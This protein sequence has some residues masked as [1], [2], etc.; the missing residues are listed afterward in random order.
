[1]ANLTKSQLIEQIDSERRENNAKFISPVQTLALLNRSLN[2]VFIEPGIKTVPEVQTLTASASVTRYA[3]EDDFK[4]L[5]SLWSGEGSL[6]GVKFDYKPIE[7]FNSTVHGY[8]YTFI[9]DGYIEVK[10]PDVGSL[11]STSLTLRYW[12]TNI[13]LDADGLTKKAVWENDEDV[14]R[15]KFFDEYFI[16]WVTARILKREG[17][18]EW[19]DYLDQAKEML[20]SLKEQPASKTTRPRRSFGHYQF[21]P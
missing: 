5:I 11:P 1:M 2:P 15:I 13:I 3:L 6:S 17:K 8:V 19:K 9:E 21:N 12:S 10:F 18:K 14:C 7:E 20:A 16:Q 4:E